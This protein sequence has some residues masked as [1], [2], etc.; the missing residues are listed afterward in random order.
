MSIAKPGRLALTVNE[1]EE[2][3]YHYVLLE[4]QTVPGDLMCFRPR[5]IGEFAHPTSMQ[6]WFAGVGAVRRAEGR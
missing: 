3:E 6:A 4:A 5:E 1:L 2:G